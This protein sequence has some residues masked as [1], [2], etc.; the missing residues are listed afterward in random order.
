[1]RKGVIWLPCEVKIRK[2]D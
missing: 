1:V 2:H